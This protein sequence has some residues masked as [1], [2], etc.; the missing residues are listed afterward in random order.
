MRERERERERERLI[1]FTWFRCR[2]VDFD[3]M[4]NLLKILNRSII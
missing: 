4:I 1:I 3:T 2:S